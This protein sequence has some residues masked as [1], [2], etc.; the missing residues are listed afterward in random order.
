MQNTSLT[1]YLIVRG[2][3]SLEAVLAR[4]TASDGL[5]F[6]IFITS[7]EMRKSLMARGFDIPKSATTIRGMV[8]QYGKIIQQKYKI[9]FQ[10]LKSQGK[11]FSLSFDEWTSSK[12]RR[13]LNINAH[14]QCT[15]FN[16]GLARVRGSL[17]A[18]SC[19]KLI[20]E[21][22]ELFGLNLHENIVCITTDGAAVM[23]K[24][25]KLLSCEQQLCLAHAIHLGVLDILYK[26]PKSVPNEEI[27]DDDDGCDS[28]D[29]DEEDQDEGFQI[30]C[31]E[32]EAEELVDKLY[33]LI[34]KVR[35]IVKLFRRSPTKNDDILQKYVKEEF[36]KKIQLMIDVKTRW[37]SLYL[38]LERFYEVKNSIL[39]SLI[40]LNSTI[41][42]EEHEWEMI[43]ILVT[44]LAPIK[45]A[46][47]ALCRRDATLISADATISFM[48]D[49]LGSNELALQMKESLSRR[50]NE[51][52][53]NAASLL[54]YL[55]TGKL[56]YGSGE[57]ELDSP[58]K[59]GRLRKTE[60]LSMII[61][62]SKPHSSN[63]SSESDSE[64]DVV[65][66]EI[67]LSLEEKLDKAIH[68]EVNSTITP[69]LRTKNL[70]N[71]VIKKELAIFEV[72]G[73][74]GKNLDRCYDSLNSIPPTS[75]ES[76]RVFSGCGKIATKIRSRLSDKSLDI[77]C[78]LRSYFKMEEKK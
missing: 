30:V 52:R 20:E 72:E 9:E 63:L 41:S 54:Q 59:F 13:Y 50:M 64:N 42:F 7:D 65:V 25:G 16:L 45:L 12:N 37:N 29:E 60:I 34:C 31:T 73:N 75:V 61:D 46:A 33:P 23:Q 56:G 68:K 18:E 11:R 67:G 74:R 78:F 36:G 62:M 15:F 6:K 58:L 39:K 51:R 17:P 76:E 48:I 1:N 35:T 43:N 53:T 21:R 66:D 4:M 28:G 44:T 40:D 26:K 22:L 14:I 69:Q 19:I 27:G 10:G 24:V 71:N 70:I 8:M 57:L 3:N 2:D 38:M 77:L 49:N 55:H 47:E 5:P 32:D